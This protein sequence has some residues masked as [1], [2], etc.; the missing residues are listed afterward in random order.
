MERHSIWQVG[1]SPLCVQPTTEILTAGSA[2]KVEILG[3]NPTGNEVILGPEE[4]TDVA[5]VEAVIVKEFLENLEC[6]LIPC[7]RTFGKEAHVDVVVSGEHVFSEHRTRQTTQIL[8]EEVVHI[9]KTK[10]RDNALET[11]MI[12]VVLFL[13]EL[14]K[15]MVF[16]F[17]GRKRRV[18]ALSC[19][20]DSISDK[21]NA[22]AC[23]S[24]CVGDDPGRVV[25][26]DSRGTHGAVSCVK[27]EI[28][29]RTDSQK[30]VADGRKVVDKLHFAHACRVLQLL[31]ALVPV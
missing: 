5:K 21:S 24:T 9:A 8:P 1:H 7:L 16:G 15:C 22:K 23:P 30:P 31:F 14:R 19:V 17:H 26:N 28:V 27:V 4:D 3:Q 11:D 29:V 20:C 6:I 10:T 13:D 2:N 12:R 25:R 18:P